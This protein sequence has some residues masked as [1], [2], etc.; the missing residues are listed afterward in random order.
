MKK[1]IIHAL[2]THAKRTLAAAFA[3]AFALGSALTLSACSGKP[4]KQTGSNSTPVPQTEVPTVSATATPAP[5]ETA[6]PFVNPT[7]PPATPVPV[8]GEYTKPCQ[9]V[10]VDFPATDS[11]RA[12]SVTFDLPE[13]W[14]VKHEESPRSDPDFMDY[15]N[16]MVE[17]EVLYDENGKIAGAVGFYPYSPDDYKEYGVKSVYSTAALGRIKLVNWDNFHPV[18]GD[19]SNCESAY[20]S[21]MHWISSWMDEREFHPFSCPVAVSYTTNTPVYVVVELSY[22]Y[23]NSASLSKCVAESIRPN[24]IRCR[25]VRWFR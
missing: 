9:K 3:A 21:S 6:T 13:G 16:S 4:A 8:V 23:E 10:K 12:F 11:T 1:H 25:L 5:E 19:S 18:D 7:Y 24:R 20:T 22:S 15:C 14:T 17:R 2:R